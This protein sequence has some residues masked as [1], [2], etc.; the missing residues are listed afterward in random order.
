MTR[1]DRAALEPKW[2]AS[3]DDRLRLAASA[4]RDELTDKLGQKPKSA[5]KARAYWLQP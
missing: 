4:S 2:S 1:Y 5:A 3:W